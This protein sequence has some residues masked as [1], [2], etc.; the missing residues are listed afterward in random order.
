MSYIIT[1]EVDTDAEMN[2]CG[3]KTKVQARIL[4]ER[5][6][7]IT[8]D[9]AGDFDPAKKREQVLALCKTLVDAGFV[10]F[11]ISHSF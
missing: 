5:D 2:L 1:A 11:S 4:S 8:F 9:V 10:E 7:C 6:G 3:D